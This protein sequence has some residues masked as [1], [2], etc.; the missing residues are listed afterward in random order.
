MTKLGAPKT[1]ASW[2]IQNDANRGSKGP[3]TQKTR[4]LKLPPDPSSTLLQ[5]ANLVPP[6]ALGSADRSTHPHG[7]SFQDISYLRE[8]AQSPCLPR[9]SPPSP[10]LL[11]DA[12]SVE[13][14]PLPSPRPRIHCLDTAYTGN[15]PGTKWAITLFPTRRPTGRQEVMLLAHWLE[16]ETKRFNELH[17]TRSPDIPEA[18]FL[19]VVVERAKAI[20]EHAF[21][22]LIRQVTVQCEERGQ[23]LKDA[24]LGFFGMANTVFTR[25]FAFSASA[26]DEAER[27]RSHLAEYE[28]KSHL[29]TSNLHHEVVRLREQLL[30]MHAVQNAAAASGAS[31][32]GRGNTSLLSLDS[33]SGSITRSSV[34]FDEASPKRRDKGDPGEQTSPTTRSG[35]LSA[36]FGS[37][38]YRS[39][40]GRESLHPQSS[41]AGSPGAVL[42]EKAVSRWAVPRGGPA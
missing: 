17:S 5:G 13:K 7:P 38:V 26:Y 39:E 21:H 10:V 6:T 42:E 28:N 12:R 8:A 36:S 9:V 20:Y 24:W 25:L 1:S 37:S 23:L 22:E 19:A 11:K 16:V 3:A 4:R 40:A 41:G 31:H 34:R 15:L 14:S 2:T 27:A 29:E 32:T 30:E 18:D 35:T 33:R